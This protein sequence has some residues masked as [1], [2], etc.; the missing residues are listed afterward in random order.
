MNNEELV[1]KIAQEVLKKMESPASGSPKVSNS[2]G[3]TGMDSSNYPLGE[4]SADKIY[5][6]TGKKLS[7]MTMQ[8]VLDGD[9]KAEDIRIAPETLNM[10]A[11][12]ADSVK[13]YPFAKNLR[14]AS[15]LIAVPDDRL[16]EIYNALR[17]GRSSQQELLDIAD[18]LRN[19]YH[20]E[21]SAKLVE[22]AAEVYVKRNKL[23]TD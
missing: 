13:N 18:E 21:D 3:N 4:K 5:S 23:R 8:Q 11:D 12:V 15:E 10:Q 17:P 19:K 7:D 9:L 1:S 14:R 20:A 22:E 6:S 16:L 2:G